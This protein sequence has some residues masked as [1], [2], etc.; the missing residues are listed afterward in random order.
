MYV[1]VIANGYRVFKYYQFLKQRNW[2]QYGIVDMAMDQYELKGMSGLSNAK[3][4]ITD[5]D[6]VYPQ[7]NRS[8]ARETGYK[9]S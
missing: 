2:D 5:R 4:L 9:E 8:K 1:I 7:T 3:N 6:T